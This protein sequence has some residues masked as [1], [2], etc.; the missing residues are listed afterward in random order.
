LRSK[1]MMLAGLAYF[2]MPADAIPDVIA[3]LGFTDDAAVLFALINV[4]GR[5]I[6]PKHKA[7]AGKLLERMS[8]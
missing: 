5:S 6:K 1:G 2:I 7:A 4:V 3:G 8:E